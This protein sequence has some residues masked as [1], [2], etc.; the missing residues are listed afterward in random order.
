VSGGGSAGSIT[1]ASGSV[2]LA[3]S[4]GTTSGAG[5]SGTSGSSGSGASGGDRPG[6]SAGTSGGGATGLTCSS[7]DIN[8]VAAT[9]SGSITVNGAAITEQSK[10]VGSLTLVNAAGDRADLG[11]IPGGSYSTL[12]APGTYD[13]YYSGES[14]T[15]VPILN[16]VKLQSGIVVGRSPLSLDIDIPATTVA[17]TVTLNGA[18][19]PNSNTSS[20]GFLELRKASGEHA[21]LADV[22]GGTQSWPIVP[23]TYDLYYSVYSRSAQ[24]LPTNTSAKLR[25]EIVVGTSPL[26]LQIDVPVTTVS[27]SVTVAGAAL[28]GVN[29]PSTL[30]TLKNA[31]GDSA[32]LTR[33]STT[34]ASSGPVIPGTYDLYYS[35]DAS[36]PGLPKNTSSKL[37]GGIVVGSSPLS[38]Q[39]DVPAIQISGKI[40][41]NGAA[42][43]A[44]TSTDIL[45]LSNVAGDK[46]DLSLSTD[47]SFSALVIPGTYD[48]VYD[49]TRDIVVPGVPANLATKLRKGLV[50]DKSSSAFD[51]DVPISTVS[52]NITL[53]GKC[54]LGPSV[55][56]GVGYVTLR[57]ADGGQVLLDGI[58]NGSFSRSVVPGT[59]DAYYGVS[60]VGPSMPI[61]RLAVL[62]KGIVVLPL[63]SII[64]NIDVPAVTVSGTVTVNGSVISD[65]T[66]GGLGRVTLSGLGGD[67]SELALTSSQSSDPSDLAKAAYTALVIPGSYELYY[68]AYRS[69]PEIPGNGKLDLG[70]FNVP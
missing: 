6:S 15:N 54:V 23:G 64:V 52:G 9:V 63:S 18:A 57:D 41:A 19:L 2:G 65:P 12:V 22:T 39:V 43:G 48:L 30:F 29:D 47:G 14:G 5:D 62:E 60:V 55:S 68:G 50:V 31:A 27:V 36:G 38:L 51:I 33:T 7:H 21:R 11:R 40:T 34:G 61:N 49:N 67:N 53:N 13:L 4:G 35:P 58:R 45:R 59:Y 69:G 1:G 56:G 25:S 16:N 32:Q 28:T 46:I 17:T 20:N 70:C 44:F 8:I 37:M 24:T 42:T 26:A 10:G 66:T 3:G